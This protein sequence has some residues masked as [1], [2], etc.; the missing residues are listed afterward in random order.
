[1]IVGRHRG[2]PDPHRRPSGARR[3]PSPSRGA[4]PTTEAVTLGA[5]RGRDHRDRLAERHRAAAARRRRRRHPDP[6][7]PAA[8]PD[9]RS[10]PR[11][12]RVYGFYSLTSPLDPHAGPDDQGRIDPAPAWDD[13]DCPADRSAPAMGTLLDSI[14]VDGEPVQH[15]RGR[16]PGRPTSSPS[17]VGGLQRGHRRSDLGH[18]RRD[19]LRRVGATRR[20]RTTSRSTG[21]RRPTPPRCSSASTTAPRSTGPTYDVGRGWPVRPYALV[22]PDARQVVHLEARSS[23]GTVLYSGPVAWPDGV[24]PGVDRPRRRAQRSAAAGAPRPS[25]LSLDC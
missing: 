4:A 13:A 20:C 17:T 5:G 6:H 22:V 8:H 11:E 12:R 1:M 14:T 23:D 15:P 9:R 18:R 24:H 2:G 10:T 7:R 16:R 21:R 19:L 3:R 25:Y